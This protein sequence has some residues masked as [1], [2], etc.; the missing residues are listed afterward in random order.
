[1][2]AELVNTRFTAVLQ[3]WRGKL[4][5]VRLVRVGLPTTYDEP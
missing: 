4:V 1:M 5:D 3:R 2:S